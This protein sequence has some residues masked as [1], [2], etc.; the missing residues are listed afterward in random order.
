MRAVD[1]NATVEAGDLVRIKLPRVVVECER[2]QAERLR[3]A[4]NA[5]LPKQIEDLL[6]DPRISDLHVLQAARTLLSERAQDV[7]NL[8]VAIEH[9]SEALG[10]DDG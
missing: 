9:A 8:S 4:L 10:G 6:H 1:V 2:R 5:V 7:E 3:D